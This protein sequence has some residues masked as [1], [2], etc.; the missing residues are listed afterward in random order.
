MIVLFKI[1]LY[2]SSSHIR[3]CAALSSFGSW[4]G[5]LSVSFSGIK[6][7]NT[8]LKFI[9]KKEDFSHVIFF[10]LYS[11]SECLE[12]QKNKWQN[13]DFNAQQKYRF[14]SSFPMCKR[15]ENS[16]EGVCYTELLW[17]MTNKAICFLSVFFSGIKKK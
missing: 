17:F 7:T 4:L 6:K 12:N 2:V 11:I 10:P 3:A 16:A 5:F 14:I 9:W 8:F 15:L 1:L 13:D